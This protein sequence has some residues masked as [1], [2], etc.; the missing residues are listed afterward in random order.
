MREYKKVLLP[1][2]ICNSVLE[3]IEKL[4]LNYEFYSIGKSLLPTITN[5]D[6]DTCMIIVNYFG[7]LDN[8]IADIA[9]A[10]VNVIV[11][12]SQ[13]FFSKPLDGVDT[14]YSPRK[15]FGVP[16]GAY[17]CSSISCKMHIEEDI[18]YEKSIH[19]LKRIDL[20]P[21][22]GFLDFREAQ[23]ALSFQPIRRMSKLT[24]A[25]LSSID[26]EFARKRRNEN[27]FF[28][29]ENLRDKNELTA[30][31]ESNA[32]D[33]PMVYPFMT[34]DPSLR[35]KLHNNRIYVATYWN[36]V[37]ERADENSL[38]WQLTKYMIPLPID[39]RYVLSD[40]RSV[41]DLIRSY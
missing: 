12:N 4:G 20:S 24:Q 40:L 3:P 18:S 11:D 41:F 36:D 10:N 8:G 16:D 26:Y 2:Y 33:G 1:R 37:F 35:K 21:E 27:F 14:V 17:L 38:E 39:Q 29:H 25:L 30:L 13:A 6:D 5:H 7:L 31:I 34:R 22:E 28:L 32:I 19:L 15:F 9:K 23:K